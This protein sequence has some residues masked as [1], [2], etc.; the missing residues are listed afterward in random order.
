MDG[1]GLPWTVLKLSL[2]SVEAK[3]TTSTGITYIAFEFNLNVV[4]LFINM[5]NMYHIRFLI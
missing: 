4:V 3:I 2:M 5:Y 1:G